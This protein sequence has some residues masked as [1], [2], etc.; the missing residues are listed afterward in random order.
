MVVC[1]TGIDVDIR[2]FAIPGRSFIF[3]PLAFGGGCMLTA[4]SQIFIRTAGVRGQV[5]RV[6]WRVEGKKGNDSLMDWLTEYRTI[7][8]RQGI[9]ERDHNQSLALPSTWLVGASASG[10]RLRGGGVG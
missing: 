4:C 2:A 8:R 5:S 3:V 1:R 10:T 6:G 7:Y 9:P